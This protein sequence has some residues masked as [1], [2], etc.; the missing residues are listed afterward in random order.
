MNLQVALRVWWLSRRLRQRERWTRPQLEAHQASS[1]HRLREH[2]YT[3]SPFYQ[4][5][6]RGLTDRPLQELP[7]LTK[8]LLMEHFDELVADPDINLADVDA[9][10]PTIRGDER[11]LGRY[12]VTATSGT[13]GRR[14]LFLF[15]SPEW[16]TILASFARAHDFTGL[17]VGITHRMRMAEVASTA[18]WHMSAR[19]GATLRSWW[20]P[21]LRLDASDP[22]DDL[23]RKLN[24]WQPEMLVAYPSIARVLA[25][26]QLAGRLHISPRLV[27]TS[28][29]VLTEET[30]LRIEDVWGKRLFDQYA[31]TECG[32]LAAECQYHTGLH[33]FEDLVIAEAVDEANRPVPPGVY[34]DKLLIT[35]LCSR[36]QPLI[37]Y[38]LSD[39]VRLAP[40]P[41][42]CGRPFALIDGVR[43]R[44]EE[45]L[46]F[47]AA[48]GGEIAVQP[49][50]FHRVLD[51][52][53]VAGWQVIQK[54]EGLV[55]L[56]S[57][58]RGELSDE[59]TVESLRR[60]LEAQGVVVPP[61][62][63]QRVQAIPRGPTGK[64]P[65][66]KSTPRQ[67]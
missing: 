57:G 23:A 38:E 53:P 31:A 26:E 14:G 25:E 22:V 55:V 52:V 47:A 34:G 41:C 19:A 17:K 20:V 33:L 66:V 44:M 7:I 46:H 35:A 27:F 10:L 45:V 48:R 13:T 9:D 12:W 62:R 56:L 54:A 36:T 16:A 51:V 28:G 42:R 29:E 4:R 21:T 2:A 39:S 3:H 30:R 64:A 40:S 1:L 8:A 60:E 67:A 15:D 5:F 37:R 50:V 61:V 65:L 6:H 49:N 24:G 18:P 11:F 63:V 43:G 58:V 59:K 32:L